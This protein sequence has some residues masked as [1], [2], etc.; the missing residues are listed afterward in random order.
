VYSRRVGPASTVSVGSAP[1][2]PLLP[3]TLSE[4]ARFH[5]TPHTAAPLSRAF[6][7]ADAAAE[8]H[9][10]LRLQTPCAPANLRAAA[11]VQYYGFALLMSASRRAVVAGVVCR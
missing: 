4:V 1:V 9:A 11:R 7:T 10:T 8:H 6:Q 3:R 5:H 2:A